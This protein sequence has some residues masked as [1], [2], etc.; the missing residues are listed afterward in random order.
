MSEPTTSTP[1]SGTSL[2]DIEKAQPAAEQFLDKHQMKLVALVVLL[3]LVALVYVVQ[4]ELKQGE[5]KT[6]G[7]LLVSKTETA[8]LEGIAKNFEGTAAAGSSKILLAEKQWEA[9][10]KDE[11]IATLRGFV[12]SAEAHPARASA[13]ASLAAKLLTQ[14]KTSDA[15]KILTELTE[16]SDAGY[17]AAYAWITLGDIAVEKDDLEAAEKAYAKVEK[18]YSENIQAV[19]DAA[20]RRLQMNAKSPVEIAAPIQPLDTK[21]IGTD[22]NPTG[23][24]QIK[25][26][27]DALKA[28]GQEVPIIPTIPLPE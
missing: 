26:I 18:D 3:I 19:Q 28:T 4:R 7:A 16:D 13:L 1:I 20:V 24:P 17:L 25:N 11:A 21:I 27:D 10:K 5:E 12:D 15:E 9:D 23:D 14:G 2:A 22:G 6:A 8:D